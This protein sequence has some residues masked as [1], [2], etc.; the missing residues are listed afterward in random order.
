MVR[1][2]G[3]RRLPGPLRLGAGAAALV[4]REPSLELRQPGERGDRYPAVAATSGGQAGRLPLQQR[5]GQVSVRV[6]QARLPE[7]GLPSPAQ[8]R[9]RLDNHQRV[10]VAAQHPGVLLAAV[11]H[12]DY[13][14]AAGVSG[15][16]RQEIVLPPLGPQRLQQGALLAALERHRRQRHHQPAAVAAAA[17]GQLELPAVQE[18]LRLS[19]R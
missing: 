10:H 8:P 3:R 14:A 13:I 7:A 1:P 9:L 16:G 6:R 2:R 5:A 11:G 15:R 17:P 4:G 12:A 19:V 18:E